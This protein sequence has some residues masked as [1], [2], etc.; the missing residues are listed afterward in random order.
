MKISDDLTIKEIWEACNNCR[1]EYNINDHKES[2]TIKGSP[3]AISYM[4]AELIRKIKTE[5]DEEQ[6]ELIKKIIIN[7]TR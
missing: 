1:L 6:F 4:M 5:L 3:I 7:S 2:C